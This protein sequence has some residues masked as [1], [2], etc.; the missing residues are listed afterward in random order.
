MKGGNSK[1]EKYL[2]EWNSILIANDDITFNGPVSLWNALQDKTAVFSDEQCS[3]RWVELKAY[4]VV[5]QRKGFFNDL[6]LVL[7]PDFNPFIL[8]IL[9]SF[10]AVKNWTY[11]FFMIETKKVFDDVPSCHI[12]SLQ[13]CD[14][15]ARTFTSFLNT[16]VIRD[17]FQKRLVIVMNKTNLAVDEKPSKGMMGK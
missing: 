5:I 9:V 1:K 15:K 8:L 7:V 13:K 3:I 11:L 6:K 12:Y 10:S 4:Y 14:L 16:Y 2:G 17:Y